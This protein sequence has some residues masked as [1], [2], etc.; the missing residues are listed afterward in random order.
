M[1]MHQLFPRAVAHGKVEGGIT[2][3]EVEYVRGLEYRANTREGIRFNAISWEQQLLHKPEMKRLYD[4]AMGMLTSYYREILG[5]P[6][7]VTPKIINSWS[8]LT[9]QGVFH[10]QHTHHNS[11]VSGVIYVN[12]D[13]SD[14]ITYY[15]TR[16]R[17]MDFIVPEEKR[18]MFNAREVSLFVEQGDI[19]IFDSDMHHAVPSVETD[20]D[21]LSIAF[22]SYPTGIWG[23]DASHITLD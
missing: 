6:D 20:H 14:R 3:E 23:Q 19:I 11:L 16:Y 2:G 15:D 22:N 12:V 5:A 13:D 18:N 9:T 7:T 17:G 1:I 8:N 21:R 10:G 4:Y